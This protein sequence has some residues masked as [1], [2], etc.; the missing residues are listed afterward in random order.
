MGLQDAV[1]E[2][3]PVE[4]GLAAAQGKARE[5][6]AVH[7]DP[8]YL[9][10]AYLTAWECRLIALQHLGQHADAAEGYSALADAEAAAF[11]APGRPPWPDLRAQHARPVWRGRIHGICRHRHGEQVL[12]CAAQHFHQPALCSGEEPE[13]AGEVRGAGLDREFRRPASQDHRRAGA[14]QRAPR[15]GT[16]AAPAT[17]AAGTAH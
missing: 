14:D 11:V 12:R 9:T 7:Y 13:R 17:A 8:G 2:A 10:K 16:L 1:A 5:L 3:G 6:M 4:A 15:R